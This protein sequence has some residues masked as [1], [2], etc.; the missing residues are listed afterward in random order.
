MNFDI[1]AKLLHDDE[2]EAFTLEEE[3]LD[4]EADL[5]KAGPHFLSEGYDQD[6]WQRYVDDDDLGDDFDDFDEEDDDFDED[7]DN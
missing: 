3:P 5:E 7:E 4:D 2:A 6:D 1:E